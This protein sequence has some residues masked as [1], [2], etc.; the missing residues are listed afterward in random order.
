MI[1]Q[2]FTKTAYEEFFRYHDFKRT[3][4]QGWLG[5]GETVATVIVTAFDSEGTEV[6]TSMISSTGPYNSTMAKFWVKAGT[7]G[8]TYTIKIKITSSAGQK[9]QENITLVVE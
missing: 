1:I 5:D 4:G 8:K 6:T 2:Q 9:F 3:D 7:A